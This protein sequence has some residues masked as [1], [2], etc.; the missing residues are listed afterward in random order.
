MNEPRKNISKEDF[1]RIL[2]TLSDEKL[3]PFILFLK[4]LNKNN[5]KGVRE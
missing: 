1:T 2:D 5:G 4:E 3:D